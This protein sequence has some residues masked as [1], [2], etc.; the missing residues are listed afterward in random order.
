MNR[1][2]SGY[3]GDMSLFPAAGR[4]QS[5][6]FRKQS[7]KFRNQIWRAFGVRIDSKISKTNVIITPLY[8]YFYT[9]GKREISKFLRIEG[10][11]FVCL[12]SGKLKN[13]FRSNMCSDFS[14]NHKQNG[15]STKF[16]FLH[17]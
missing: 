6:R 14:L 12:F 8:I 9:L 5:D 2:G 11:V 15:T 13:M 7:S 4:K 3:W 17:V 16:E 1:G 10:R